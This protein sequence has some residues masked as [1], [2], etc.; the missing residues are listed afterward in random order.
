[1]LYVCA[2]IFKDGPL[3]ENLYSYSINPSCRHR[4][5]V[6]FWLLVVTPNKVPTVSTSRC[7]P[8]K[9]PLTLSPLD[10]LKREAK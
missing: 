7:W 8:S 1:M 10:T 3:L 5:N 6:L 2:Y 9:S 4:R